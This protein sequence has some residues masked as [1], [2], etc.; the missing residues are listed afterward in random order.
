MVDIL[1]VVLPTF[2]VILVGFLIGK[3][4]KIDMSSIV[5]VLFWVGIPALAFTSMLDKKIV[6][7]DAGKVWASSLIIMFGCGIVAWIV[8]RLLRQKHSGV[9]LPI[10]LMNT[11][12]IPFPIISLLYGDEGIF[13]AVLFYIPNVIALYSLGIIILSRKNWKDGL[14]EMAKVP[15]I[16]AA[17][18]GF[19]CNLLT[20][21]VPNLVQQP[22]SL[23]GKMV[24][25]LALLI[26]G[27]KLASVK[28]TSFPTTVIASVIR[29][30]VG[31]LLGFAATELFHLT[32]IL[33]TVV[34]FDSAMPA[35]VNTTLLA[36]KYEN[37][38][39]LVSSVVFLTTIASLVIIP[40]L[41]WMLG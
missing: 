34:I 31:L 3:L 33:R 18:I 7:A 39:E 13:A 15:A 24:V 19:A 22:L 10:M 16:Y 26:L 17:V 37:E 21:H 1:N 32:G 6:L 29:I 28:I 27:F 35:A 9:Y 11:V 40:F 25:P 4:S 30:G 5:D 36:M 14:K 41:V 2:L 12:N 38:S 23:I 20:V 8:F